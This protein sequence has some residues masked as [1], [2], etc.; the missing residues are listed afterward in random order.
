MKKSIFFT[1]ILCFLLSPIFTATAAAKKLVIIGDSLTE[2]LGVDKDSAFPAVLEKLLKDTGKNN[3]EVVNSGISASTSASALSRVNWILKSK[4]D[5]ILLA[6]GANDGL[7][8]LS[9]EELKT[10]L[11][12]A[13]R[14]AKEQNIKVMLAGMEMPPNYGKAYTQKFHEVYPQLAREE[15]IALLPFLLKGV[16]GNPKLNQ[17]D[18]I[19]PNEAGHKIVAKLVYDFLVNKL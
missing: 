18:G 6:L 11:Q 7:R 9:T 4:P 19:H 8:N 12:K 10:N 16:A 13:I 17:A 14:K 15:K 3:W 2:G 1:I 5:L